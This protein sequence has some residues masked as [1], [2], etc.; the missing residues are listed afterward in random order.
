MF[1]ANPGCSGGLPTLRRDETGVLHVR[2]GFA[3]FGVFW[4][5]W[6]VAALDVQAFLGLSDT[7]LGL[8]VAATVVGTPVANVVGGTLTER[9]GVGRALAVSLVLWA[10][11]VVPLALV[12]SPEWWM[13]AFLVAVAAGGLLDVVLNVASTGALADRPGR[14]LRVHAS[15]QHRRRRRRRASPACCWPP[16][17][18]WRWPFAARRP[19]ARVVLA[20]P[21]AR[22]RRHVPPHAGHGRAST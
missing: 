5:T 11:A 2:L 1:R 18:S 14:L 6:A 3:L 21:V 13:A 17:W 12:R 7:G 9:I 16:S 10:V 15:L 19:S 20:V 22:R 8:L 4:G